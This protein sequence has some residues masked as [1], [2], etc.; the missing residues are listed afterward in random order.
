MN[1]SINIS[2]LSQLFLIHQLWP[3]LGGLESQ[4]RGPL[5]QQCRRGLSTPPP[6]AQHKRAQEPHRRRPR[7]RHNCNM[8]VKSHS[9]L[10]HYIIFWFTCLNI[11]SLPTVTSNSGSRYESSRCCEEE[12]FGEHVVC[13]RTRRRLIQC[14]T[15]HIVLYHIHNQWPRNNIVITII[16]GH[17]LL[18]HNTHTVRCLLQTKCW[19]EESIVMVLNIS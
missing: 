6:L 10:F 3:G 4:C 2:F 8:K 16:Q 7:G 15:D 1:Q 14:Q 17:S 13:M 9:S 18:Y 5:P 12:N 19:E 11:T